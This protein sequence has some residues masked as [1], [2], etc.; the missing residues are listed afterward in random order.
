MNA[1]RSIRGFTVTYAGEVYGPSGRLL[2]PSPRR[3]SLRVSR[4]VGGIKTHE[5]VQRLV[6]EAFHG[7][8][9]AWATLVRHLDGDRLNNHADNLAW[10]TNAENQADLA[11]HGHT[12]QGEKHHNAKLTQEQVD[13][14]RACPPEVTHTELGRKYG[15]DRRTV[16]RIRNG[17]RWRHV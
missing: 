16:S 8:A 15:V 9:P 10:G 5:S 7:P 13:E 14:I 6:C 12:V 3:G 1:P 17:M 11:A 2:S 4:R